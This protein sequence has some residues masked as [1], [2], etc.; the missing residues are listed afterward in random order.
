MSRSLSA[1]NELVYMQLFLGKFTTEQNILAENLVYF[2][3]HEIK[4]IFFVGGFGTVQWIEVEDYM[5]AAP[6]S[7]VSSCSPAE[8]QVWFHRNQIKWAEEFYSEPEHEVCGQTKTPSQSQA[9]D[10]R[11]GDNFGRCSGLRCE[12]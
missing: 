1:G 7:I 4:D 8:I 11:S 3:M 10:P 12:D 6:D 2:R 5:K 9:T